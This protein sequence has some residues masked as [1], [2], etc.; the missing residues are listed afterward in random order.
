MARWHRDLLQDEL[1]RAQRHARAVQILSHMGHVVRRAA[2]TRLAN[3]GQDA[4]T[5]SLV[6]GFS[7]IG[8]AQRHEM[9]HMSKMLREFCRDHIPG[10]LAALQERFPDG[11]PSES[12]D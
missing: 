5:L 9:R 10:G 2:G 11:V 7:R 3:L 1:A 4:S 12:G 6:Q 8:R